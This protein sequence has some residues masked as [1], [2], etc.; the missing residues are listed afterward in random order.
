[1]LSFNE[2]GLRGQQANVCF[3]RDGNDDEKEPVYEVEISKNKFGSF[4]GRLFF[5]FFPE[6]SYFREISKAQGAQYAQMIK[7]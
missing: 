5:Q 6:M 4:K 2:V 7:S 3:Y 1:M